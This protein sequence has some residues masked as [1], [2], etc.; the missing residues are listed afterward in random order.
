MHLQL[1]IT[2]PCSN[3]HFLM[4]YLS[5]NAKNTF[6]QLCGDL[7]KNCFLQITFEWDTSYELLIREVVEVPGMIQII[8]VSLYW[9]PKLDGKILLMKPLYEIKVELR[10]RLSSCWLAFI[11][12]GGAMEV[13]GVGEPSMNA[14]I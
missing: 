6:I 10:G 5:N 8:S 2:I 3:P 9:L 13:T 4:I 14:P 1:S 11:V 12:Q 7:I